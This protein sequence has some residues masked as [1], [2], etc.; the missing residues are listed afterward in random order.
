M[1]DSVI[2]GLLYVYGS[3]LSFRRNLLTDSIFNGVRTAHMEVKKDIPSTVRIA[4]ELIRFWYPVQPKTCRRCGDLGHLIKECA[5]VRCFN[6]EQ[7]GHRSEE[8]EMPPLCSICWSADHLVHMCPYFCFS[9][10]VTVQTVQNASIPGSY[11][12]AAK[13]PRT[14]ALYSVL[15]SASS[16]PSED[17]V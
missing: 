14:V 12:G 2:I 10:N 3:V 5:S 4:G 15:P 8:C 7:S 6:C 9:A 16:K 11:A 1:P 13:T 17:Q